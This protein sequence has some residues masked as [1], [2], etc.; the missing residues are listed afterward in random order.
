MSININQVIAHEINLEKDSVGLND[1]VFS[2]NS[3][4]TVVFDFFKDHISTSLKAKQ[5]KSCKFN[6]EGTYVQQKVV[7]I[8]SDIEEKSKFVSISRDLAT[9]FF[10]KMK[11]TSS[12]SHGTLFFLI[13]NYSGKDYLGILKMDP[14]KG[15]QIDIESN[16]LKVQENMLPN[17]EHNLHKCAFIKLT[18]NF[19]NEDVHLD[20]LDRQQKPGEVSKFFM[21]TFLQATEILNDKIMTQRIFDTLYNKSESISPK[22]KLKYESHVERLMKNGN[23]F[24]FDKSVDSLLI[25]FMEGE[26]D[27]KQ[28]IEGIKEEIRNEYEDVK[29]QFT[30]EKESTIMQ[31]STVG[32]ELKIE[33]KLDLLNDKIEVDES[34]S[35]TVITIR[36]LDLIK[37]YR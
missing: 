13:Y 7:R 31:Y 30:V 9:D 23:E 8:A 4:P 29:F 6:D 35:K 17:P 25:P 34:G 3:I 26:E 19:S 15:I 2:L 33:F 10:N 1:A 28:M 24:D 20:V 18:N 21:S 22:D 14:N 12:Q 37:K 27:R 5:I 32:K 36:D 11:G 16:E